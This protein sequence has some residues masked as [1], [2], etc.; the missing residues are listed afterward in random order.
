[1]SHPLLEKHR[2]TLDGALSAIASRG[3]WSAYP[4][5]PS[6]KLYGETAPEDGKKAYEAHLGQRFELGQPGQKDWHGGEKSPYG[7]EL[8]VQYP[9][10][11]IEAL[12]AAGEAAMGGWQRIGADGRAGVCLEILQRLNQQSF[13][14]AHAVMMTTGQGW[15]MAFQAGAPHAQDRG[16]EAVA[17]AYREQ[18]FVPAE[19]V[20]EKPQGKNPPLVLKKHFEVVGRGI[21]VVVGCGTFPTWNTYPGLFA[22]LATGNAVIVKPHSNAILPAAITVRTIRAVLAENGLD[23]NLVTLAVAN[24]RATTQKLVT[25]AKVKSI[26]FTGGNVF[27]QWL[28]DNCRQAQVYA[29]LAGVNNIVVDSTDSYKRMLGNLAFTLALYSGQMCTTSQALFVPAGGIETD[30]GHKSYDEFCADLAQAVSGFLAK[31]EVAHAVLGAVQSADTLKRIVEADSGSL[32][33]VVLASS[34]LENPEFPQA[35]VRTP[36]LLACDAADEAAY[37][38]ERFG[39]ISF[40][41]KVADTAAAIALSERIVSTHGALTAGLYSTSEAVIEAMTEATWRS[42]VAL[43]INLTGGVFVNQSAA[44]SDYHGTGGNPAANASYADS[45]FVANR[46]R[47]VQRRYHV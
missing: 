22:A 35:E 30:Q 31:P 33:K 12:I 24:D 45:A 14:L 32:G 4:E 15:M 38:E 10:C 19:T 16:L 26:D 44:F 11:D 7:V 36:V 13:E 34:K 43:S 21:G 42:K 9:V 23:A 29:E 40:I 17:Y 2:A 3:Y 46:F 8:G 28:I 6:P 41:V 20:W 25:H 39:P 37:M 27:G 47:V 1:M 5:M 18:A